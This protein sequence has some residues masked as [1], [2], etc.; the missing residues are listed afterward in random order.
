MISHQDDDRPRSPQGMQ[1]VCW[2][3]GIT[4]VVLVAW[5]IQIWLLGF[6][7][8]L[9]AIYLNT[10]ATGIRR[11][12]SLPYGWSLAVVL[13]VTLG[14]ATLAIGWMGAQM[15]DQIDQA[16][17]KLGDAVAQ[18]RQQI[19]KEPTLRRLF[20]TLPGTDQLLSSTAGS[21]ATDDFSSPAADEASSSS[22]SADLSPDT[23]SELGGM[24][25]GLSTA[26][27]LLAALGRAFVVLLGS[28]AN[29]TL[30][31]FV[32]VF[33]AAS[34]SLYRRGFIQLISPR[35]RQRVTALLDELGSTLWRWLVGRALAMAVTGGGTGVILWL[36]GVPLPFTM[37]LLTAALTFI[38][39]IGAAVAMAL[40]VLLAL[41]MGLG[42]VGSVVV[43]YLTLQLLESN[44]LTPIIQQQQVSI[45][46]AL[47]ILFQMVMGI[48]TGTLGI[49]VA[50]P[51]LASLLVLIRRL[52]VQQWLGWPAD[53][54][55]VS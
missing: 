31:L 50:T 22:A 34:P 40:A 48:L 28:V 41:P 30:V 38:P 20:T 24:K 44:V 26:Q 35:Y 17:E 8:L 25:A 39:N 1:Y 12:T 51:I 2:I 33:L 18:L 52:Y 55:D 5:T 3:I 13:T 42:V 9:F 27:G 32:G 15:V 45:P 29:M 46:P 37:A 49:M 16:E 4:L 47:L 6:L 11:L 53:A 10:C 36:L 43:A 54:V 19:E 23:F 14:G 7:G 21:A